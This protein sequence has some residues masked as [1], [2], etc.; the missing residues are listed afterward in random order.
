VVEQIM[1]ESSAALDHLART[2]TVRL[3]TTTHD[4]REI[5]TKI[6]AVVVDGQA[7]IRNAYGDSSHWYRRIQRTKAAAFIDGR[8]RYDVTVENVGD[9]ETNRQVDD[10]FNSK[11]AGSGP[12]LR[13][14]ITDDARRSTMRVTPVDQTG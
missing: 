11:Y 9:E 14:M 10:A 2:G 7:Y 8:N 1:A 4:G 5:V 6:W 12:A 3:A 13:M